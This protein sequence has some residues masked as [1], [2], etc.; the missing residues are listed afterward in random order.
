MIS[1]SKFGE[2]S[3]PDLEIFINNPLVKERLILIFR[4]ILLIKQKVAF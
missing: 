2:Y 1:F 4:R 3:F